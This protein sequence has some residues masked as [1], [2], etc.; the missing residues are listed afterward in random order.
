MHGALARTLQLRRER[1]V[2]KH[3]FALWVEESP[4]IPNNGIAFKE[5][6]SLAEIGWEDVDVDLFCAFIILMYEQ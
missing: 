2:L 4:S 6:S 5:I 1:S 3:V